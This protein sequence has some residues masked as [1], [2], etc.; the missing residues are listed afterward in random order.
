MNQHLYTRVS[1]WLTP[2][3]LLYIKLALAAAALLVAAAAPHL[4]WACNPGSS[5]CGS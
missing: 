2:E 1:L 5:G 3:R 4:A